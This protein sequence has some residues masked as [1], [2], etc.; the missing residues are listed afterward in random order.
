MLQNLIINEVEKKEIP[1]KKIAMAIDV[2]PAAI[3]SFLHG[4]SEINFYS[5]LKIVRYLFPEKE[6]EVIPMY[7]RNLS[8]PE[9]IRMAME[10]ASQQNFLSLLQYLVYSQLSSNNVVNREWARIYELDYKLKSGETTPQELL[11][12]LKRIR[13][14]TVEM[15]F[16]HHWIDVYYSLIK[17]DLFL[18]IHFL[19]EQLEILLEEISEPFLYKCFS[20]RLYTV[21][22]NKYLYLDDTEKSR[23]YSQEGIKN[24]ISVESVARMH[25]IK[26]L[27]YM[28]E[29]GDIAISH[30]TTA[31]HL[32]QK[33]S[34]E[35][36]YVNI[37][38]SLIFTSSFWRKEIDIKTDIEDLGY[39]QEIAHH[40][41]SKGNYKKAKEILLNINENK[42][43][44]Y[45]KCFQYYYLG[46]I[47]KDINYFYKSLMLFNQRGDK[48]FGKL[49][50]IE[51]LK[52]GEK[53]V[54]VSAA[55]GNPLK[56]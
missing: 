29:D 12:R 8:K 16:M 15:V 3:S 38:K 2:S 30:L 46:L 52:A 6:H 17:R 5:A 42:L 23:F 32:Y 37:E 40:Y 24:N 21:L 47:E 44:P 48:F 27:S 31:K 10:Y 45:P 51:L 18:V 1:F 22:A 9:N 43:E 50:A 54:A 4:K 13:V 14:N 56:L 26:G 20:T 55:Y 49:P 33:I 41:I 7:I 53:E 39:I 11:I 34:L 19:N 36:Q 35:V 25:H 28:F